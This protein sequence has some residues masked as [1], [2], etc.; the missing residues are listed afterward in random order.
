MA[1]QFAFNTAAITVVASC[2]A[3]GIIG[4]ASQANPKSGKTTSSQVDGTVSSFADVLLTGGNRTVTVQRNGFL[5]VLGKDD[6]P[7]NQA[8]PVPA[9]GNVL[10]GPVGPVVNFSSGYFATGSGTGRSVF[11]NHTFLAPFKSIM[12]HV[13]K[14]KN[15]RRPRPSRPPVLGKGSDPALRRTPQALFELLRQSIIA[16]DIPAILSI[17]DPE[18]GVVEFGGGVARG[19]EEIFNLYDNFFASDPVLNARPLQII[20]AGGVAIILGDYTLEFKDE[21]G[22]VQKV[23]GKFGDIVRQERNGKS[24]LYLLDNPY[25]PF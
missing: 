23:T 22:V 19:A 18:A 10:F 20:E 16:R 14:K 8:A 4:S 25:A 1:R 21:N 15:D 24:W 9:S 6:A 3:L 17:H 12:A 11:Q 13:P 2:I 7:L 5:N